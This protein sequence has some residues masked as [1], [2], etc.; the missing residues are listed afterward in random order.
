MASWPWPCGGGGGGTRGYPI[1]PA[2]P[3]DCAMRMGMYPCCGGSSDCC[4]SA[5]GSGG[6]ML[7]NCGCVGGGLMGC[8]HAR[9]HTR[10]LID[11]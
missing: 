2:G 1:G 4:C 7:C 9:K 6:A 5:L 11:V 8:L 3:M 10:A